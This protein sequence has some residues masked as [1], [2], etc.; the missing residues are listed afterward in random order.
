MTKAEYAMDQDTALTKQFVGM[1]PQLFTSQDVENTIFPD[2]TSSVDEV[3]SIP[4][5]ASIA[6]CIC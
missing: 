3:H 5:E 6:V 2:L 4:C 1:T